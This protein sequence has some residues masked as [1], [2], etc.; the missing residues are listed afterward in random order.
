MN[1]IDGKR[2]TIASFVIIL[3]MLLGTIGCISEP[4]NIKKHPGVPPLEVRNGLNFLLSLQRE[5]GSICENDSMFNVWET[6]NSANAILI[7]DDYIDV[8]YQEIVDKSISFLS[9]S[10]NQDGMVLQSE[11]HSGSYCLETSSEYVCLLAHRYSS[12]EPKVL[13]KLEYIKSQQ[14]A[15]GCWNITIPRIPPE[16]QQFPSAT[17]FALKS[18]L[19]CGYSPNDLR[20]AINFL[21]GSQNDD[22]HWGVE[23]QYYGTPYYAM[24][25]IL[26]VLHWCRYE[27]DNEEVIT[28]VQSYLVSSQNDNGSWFYELE[29]VPYIPSPELQSAMALQCCLYSGLDIKNDTVS[30][31]IDWLLERQLSDGHWDGGF[32]PNRKIKKK[33]DIYATSQS[34]LALHQYWLLNN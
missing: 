17:G 11:N 29:G 26:W 3:I 20:G 6:V 9:N 10:E 25:P 7:W 1:K 31:G 18:L 24:A 23:W 16:L 33:E 28:N 19:S 2:K 5:D 14:L 34:L 13:E 15:P 21:H 4:E 22:G 8:D 27:Y 30:R 32:F 12:T